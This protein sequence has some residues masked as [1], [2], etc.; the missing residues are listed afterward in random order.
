MKLKSSRVKKILREG[1]ICYGTMLRMLRTP[2]AVALC[3]SQHWDYVILD[4]EHNDYD[5]E[6]LS[7]FCLASKYVDMDLYVRVPDKLYHQMAQMLD[8]GAEGLILPQVR[9]D[10]EARRIINAT[11]YAPLGKRG[12]SLSETVTLFGDYSQAAY[13][14]WA[15]E[16]LMNIIQI[17]S[18]EGVNNVGKILSNKGI[19]AVMIGPADMSQ[20]MGISGQLEH[21]RLEEAFHE[22]IEQCNKYDV[23]PGIHFSKMEYVEKWVKEGMRFVTYSYDSKFIKD[24]YSESL[25]KLRSFKPAQTLV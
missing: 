21:P 23:A 4:T 8:V 15:N 24:A 9:T 14:Q 12:V 13:T 18:E 20:D 3:A 22:I 11:K 2:Q 5:L 10:E 1:G 7:N 17:E 6:T 25:Q 16:E 19:D